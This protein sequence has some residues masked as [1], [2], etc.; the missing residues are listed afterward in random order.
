MHVALD[1]SDLTSDRLDGTTVYA[2]ELLP[3]LARL[4]ADHG[5]RVTAFAPRPLVAPFPA[6]DR[7]E[8]RQLRGRR[9]WTQT[10][11][12]R[13]LFTVQPDILFLPIQTV[14][15]YRPRGLRVVATVH[16]LDFL[17]FPET[18][19]FGNRLLLRWFT[20]VVARN[21]SHLIAVSQ[22]TREAVT[23]HYRRP[24][25]DITVVHHGYDEHR[26]RVPPAEE[27]A[28]ETARVRTRYHLPPETILFVGA[29]QP[30][31]N[32][33]GLLSAYEELVRAGEERD[34]VI[35]SGNAWKSS[36]IL[37]RIEAS[38][39]NSRIHLLRSVP[40]ED[41]PA[42]Y[43]NAS[44]LVLPSFAEGFGLPVI[45][46]M[47]CGIPTVVSR[48]T[49]LEEIAGGASE[50]VDPRDP[51]SIA[52][53][54]KYVLSNPQRGEELRTQGRERARNFSWDRCADETAAVI[55][56]ISGMG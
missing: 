28:S 25:E 39:A 46:A 51:S 31:K 5:H 2:R 10:V 19:T 20:R 6:G 54:M 18:Y 38:E 41:L 12:S 21:A 43:W 55:E 24:P 45:E 26:F 29:L 8:F 44:V 13:A 17:N 3:R 32:I 40:H 53:G 23:R 47:A 34:L 14:P 56:K 1:A 11:L 22:T 52:L 30:R 50:I 36:G 49:A 48:G 15:L 4:L 35:V 9:F 37:D 33:A 27:R 16:D 7:I 42:I